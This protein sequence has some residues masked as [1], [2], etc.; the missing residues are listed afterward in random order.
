MHFPPV[1]ATGYPHAG[2]LS[3][4]KPVSNTASQQV[5]DQAFIIF[6]T[7]NYYPAGPSTGPAVTERKKHYSFK[8]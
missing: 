6:L 4:R 1:R 3:L 7:T 8:I 5:A 2:V